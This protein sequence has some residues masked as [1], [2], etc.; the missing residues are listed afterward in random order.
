MKNKLIFLI[1][2]SAL[3]LGILSF[4]YLFQIN[5]ELKQLYCDLGESVMAERE[6]TYPILRTIDDPSNYGKG[7]DNPIATDSKYYEHC[8]GNRWRL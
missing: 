5:K 8:E 3:V 7:V 1:S 6:Y 2:I 4:I